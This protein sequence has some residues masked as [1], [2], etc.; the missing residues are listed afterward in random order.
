MFTLR[1][2]PTGTISLNHLVWHRAACV[3]RTLITGAPEC[4]TS[5]M[6]T[7][8]DFWDFEYFEQRCFVFKSH[9]RYFLKR[10]EDRTAVCSVVHKNS[11]QPRVWEAVFRRRY[12]AV[13]A[14][15]GG[16]HLNKT[17]NINKTQ[18]VALCS[19]LMTLWLLYKHAA[20]HTVSLSDRHKP[21]SCDL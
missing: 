17:F 18:S 3:H 7:C 6:G 13:Q 10:Q 20:T 14:K 5:E 9:C 16:S 12:I 4:F 21:C 11:Y 8:K 1:Y 15:A 2:L 19:H